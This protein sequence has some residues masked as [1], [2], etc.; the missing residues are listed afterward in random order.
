MECFSQKNM[1]RGVI[2]K[3]QSGYILCCVGFLLTSFLKIFLVEYSFIT[4]YHPLYASLS[5]HT[6]Q[7]LSF[8]EVSIK[9]QTRDKNITL[10]RK[11][12]QA[13]KWLENIKLSFW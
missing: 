6:T 9:F 10:K 1:G 3:S 12:K 4:P 11:E 5:V 8:V 2:K 13:G 7:R